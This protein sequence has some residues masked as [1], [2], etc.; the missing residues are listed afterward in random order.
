MYMTPESYWRSEISIDLVTFARKIDNT[1][2]PAKTIR[3]VY[4]SRIVGKFFLIPIVLIITR[5]IA[6][7]R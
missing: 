1:V 3:L 7:Q 5:I 6:K 4:K 2:F